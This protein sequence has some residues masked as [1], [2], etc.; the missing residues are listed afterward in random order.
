MNAI[1]S[2]LAVSFKTLSCSHLHRTRLHPRDVFDRSCYFGFIAEP[3][4]HLVGQDH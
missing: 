4:L 2:V 3:D 1:P